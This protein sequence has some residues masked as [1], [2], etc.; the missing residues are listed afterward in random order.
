MRETSVAV[1]AI[2]FRNYHFKSTQLCSKFFLNNY[3]APRKR[4]L[5]DT[6]QLKILRTCINIDVKPAPR[7]LTL[8]YASFSFTQA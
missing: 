2:F 7:H 3:E 6:L 1:K 8:L 5:K 4:H